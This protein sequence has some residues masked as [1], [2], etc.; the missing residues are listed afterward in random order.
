LPGYPARC[1]VDDADPCD[2]GERSS[3]THL[4]DRSGVVSG[5]RGQYKIQSHLTG[6]R[7][8]NPSAKGSC[9]HETASTQRHTKPYAIV[10]VTNPWTP[11]QCWHKSYQQ[12][13]ASNHIVLLLRNK[14]DQVH[15]KKK[16]SCHYSIIN[17]SV[18]QP[19]YNFIGHWLIFQPS[20]TPTDITSSALAAVPGGV[21]LGENKAILVG[22]R[23]GQRRE[24]EGCAERQPDCAGSEGGPAG[25][26]K[27]QEVVTQRY[28][29]TWVYAPRVAQRARRMRQAPAGRRSE[30]EADTE[31]TIRKSR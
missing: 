22:L 14:G 25:L 6:D 2:F 23:R 29:A 18:M 24:Q 8:Y 5:F 26:R 28:E 17:K 3:A 30:E 10:V 27:E 19:I 1:C 11:I 31:R 20:I 16:M 7:S 9:E 21:I 13:S 12:I 4:S 15:G